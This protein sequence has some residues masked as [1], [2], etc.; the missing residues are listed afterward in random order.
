[1]VRLR[2]GAGSPACH[3]S[4][5]GSEGLA[6]LPAVGV[7]GAGEPPA[8]PPREALLGV[9]LGVPTEGADPAGAGV[10]A[11]RLHSGMLEPHCWHE[12]SALPVLPIESAHVSPVRGAAGSAARL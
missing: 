4:E 7:R 6:A 10:R 5:R 3:L 1:M 9:P 8:D 11:A 2:S 12:R